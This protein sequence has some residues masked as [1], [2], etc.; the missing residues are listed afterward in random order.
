[1][2]DFL[3]LHNG[4][5]LW[6]CSK[7]L[8]FRIEWLSHIFHVEAFFL[9]EA[10]LLLIKIFKFDYLF[11]GAA[12]PVMLPSLEHFFKHEQREHYVEGHVTLE[13]TFATVGI[14]VD[15]C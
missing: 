8:L 6:L 7:D 12:I 5:K 3:S 15:A 11:I 2:T 4:Y 9:R 14:Y 1:M 13:D 10:F